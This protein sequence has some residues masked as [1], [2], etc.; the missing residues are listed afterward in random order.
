MAL[1]EKILW[2]IAKE[3]V[4][5]EIKKGFRM[6]AREHQVVKTLKR[7]GF[8]KLEKDFDSIYTHTLVEFGEDRTPPE[9]VYLFATQEVIDAF[10]KDL[11]QETAT[12]HRFLEDQLHTNRNLP[13]ELKSIP[14]LRSIKDDIE[15]FCGF[16]DHLTQQTA[17]PFSLKMHNRT[18]EKVLKLLEENE[19]KSFDYQTN[20][21][22]QQKRKEFQEEF[23]EEDLFIP[24]R[25]EKRA[26][27]KKV[28]LDKYLTKESLQ[29]VDSSKE[30]LTK[31]SLGEVDSIINKWLEDDSKNLLILMGEYG[32]GK[33]TLMRYLLHQ[34]AC[35][36]LET[37]ETI[38]IVDKAQRIPLFLPLS[39]FEGTIES[40]ITTI[41][42]EYG[43]TDLTFK[44]FQDKADAGEI[45]AIFDGFDETTQSIDANEKI[46]NFSQIRN[47]ISPNSKT[48]F[49]LTCREEYFKSYTEIE[50]LFQI[51]KNPSYEVLYLKTFEDDQ[52]KQFLKRTDN[53][54][55]YWKKINDIF[56]LHDLA[57]RPVLL[58]LIVKHL[59]A[60]IAEKEE[61]ESIKAADL[62]ERSI[63]DELRR[64][65]EELP[66]F[67]IR[68]KSRL[69]ILKKL[70][71]WMYE[72]DTLTFDTRTVDEELQ[73]S[74]CFEAKDSW[75]KEKRLNEFL[76]FTFLI[77]EGSN[78]KYRISHKS[79]RDYLTATVWLEEIHTGNIQYFGKTEAT[80]EMRSFILEQKPDKG[81]LLNLVLSAKNLTIDTQWQGTNAVNLLLAIDVEGLAGQNLADCEIRNVKFLEHSLNEI[82]SFSIDKLYNLTETVVYN[83]NLSGCSFG[84]NILQAS[85]YKNA[86]FENAKL[87][88]S[89]SKIKDFTFLEKM[90]QISELNIYDSK[91]IE[92][93]IDLGNFT[94]LSRLNLKSTNIIAVS[95]LDKLKKLTYLN[96]EDT[97]LEDIS[98]LKELN[99]LTSLSLNSFMLEDISSLKELSNLTSLSLMSSILKDISVLKELSNL[100]SIIIFAHELEDISALKEL[101]NL[102][103]LILFANNIKDI[104]AL[105]ELNTLY[106]LDLSATKVEDVSALKELSNLSSLALSRNKIVDI[107]ILKEFKKLSFLSLT[108]GCFNKKQLEILKKKNLALNVTT[109]KTPKSVE[110]DNFN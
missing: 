15:I 68:G 10:K 22:L 107:S 14:S 32:T 47:L 102:N 70:A 110:I 103:S 87:Y 81:N 5:S 42:N 3:I 55:F 76:T 46:R 16:F 79:F 65:E 92:K 9:L 66:P 94:K 18:H 56:D 54:D 13:K 74:Q 88:F 52:I 19:R 99:N 97:E 20:A 89:K 82:G 109:Y 105:K 61:G 45:I 26:Y 85:N 78:Y 24:L 25:V 48:K 98:A 2:E 49:I 44:G 40:M 106:H 59:P 95:E 23:L 31:T 33:T 8:A 60:I 43:I 84:E 83:T 75:E 58:E 29:L 38:S 67:H 108:E 12:F 93:F 91:H 6:L 36:K 41:C 64:K 73:L 72:K 34:L 17:N 80:E 1:T 37:G 90:N 62:Y 11:Y 39:K 77:R 57:K 4:K 86:N 35:H 63:N 27:V 96:I 101:S 50:N 100:N 7:Y 30:R 104:S 21:Y 28:Q 53:P 51:S 71:C 69:E